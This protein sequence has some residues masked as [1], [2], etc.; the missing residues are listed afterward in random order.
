MPRLAAVSPLAA[1]LLAAV[2]T[3]GCSNPATADGHLPPDILDNLP[4]E[5]RDHTG[6]ASDEAKEGHAHDGDHADVEPFRVLVFSKTAAFRH[7]WCIPD[8]IQMIHDFGEEHGFDVDDTEDSTL[9]TDENLAQ[10][11]VVVFNNTTGDVLDEAQED[12]FERFIRAGGGYVGIHAATDTEYD[13]PWYNELVGGYFAGH[14]KTQP[15]KHDVV[16]GDHP[17]TEHLEPTFVRTDEWYNFKSYNDGVNVLLT[18]D[19]SSYEGGQ[20]GEVHP[21]AWYHD[22]DGGRAWYTGGGHT[23]EA[24]AEPDWRRHVLGGLF[25]AAGRALPDALGKPATEADAS[26]ED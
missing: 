14:P 1:G 8:G 6:A 2:A 11:A 23:S 7:K 26:A 4:E 13:W 10:Y 3:L 25:W 9:F 21:I 15:A 17:S 12:A 19:E 5:A 22:F 20:M 16:D 18:I 24:Y